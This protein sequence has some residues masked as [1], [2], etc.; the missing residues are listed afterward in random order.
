EP[1][2]IDVG[3]ACFPAVAVLI[4]SI[5]GDLLRTGMDS[6]VA[7]VAVTGT[8][9]QALGRAAPLHPRRAAIPVTVQILV[10]EIRAVAVLIDAVGRRL[11]ASRMDRGG[12]V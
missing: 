7:L 4:H 8:T 9:D 2:P 11:G 6:A 12:F 3:G 1:V 5:H 10:A